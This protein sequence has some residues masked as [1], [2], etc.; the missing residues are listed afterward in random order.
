MPNETW[1][2]N[3]MSNKEVGENTLAHKEEA[4]EGV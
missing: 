3:R 4:F 1:I 2:L